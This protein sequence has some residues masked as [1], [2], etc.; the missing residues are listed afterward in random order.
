MERKLAGT[1]FF[2]AFGLLTYFVTRGEWWL[3]VASYA[4][5]GVLLRLLDGMCPFLYR[6][7]A[8]AIITIALW[9]IRALVY[10]ASWRERSS[11]D[12]RFA[13]GDERFPSLQEA[14]AVAQRIADAQG[15]VEIILE[16]GELCSQLTWWELVS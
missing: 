8:P 1:A 13:V 4:G 15:E 2:A 11:S 16:H 14:S 6:P 10:L 7:T 3:A 9:P 5:C 12:E